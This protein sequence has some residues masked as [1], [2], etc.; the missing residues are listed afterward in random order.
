VSR[1]IACRQSAITTMPPTCPHCLHRTLQIPSRMATQHP[2]RREV[3]SHTRKGQCAADSWAA[4]FARRWM[5]AS[6]WTSTL[7]ADNVADQH[8]ELAAGRDRK[9]TETHPP[10]DGVLVHVALAV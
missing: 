6:T 9:K 2:V 8:L 4:R 3:G 1:L 10:A 5:S 7:E